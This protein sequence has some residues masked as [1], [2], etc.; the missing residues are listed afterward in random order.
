M[1]G[2]DVFVCNLL[3]KA[4]GMEGLSRLL[5]RMEHVDLRAGDQ[6][7]AVGMPVSHLCFIESGLAS[8]VIHDDSGK[9]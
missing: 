4:L 7:V 1:L 8:T 6:L 3:L 5:S 2:S 9:S